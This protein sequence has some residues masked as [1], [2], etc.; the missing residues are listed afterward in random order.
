MRKKYRWVLRIILV[1]LLIGVKYFLFID[2]PVYINLKVEEKSDF[3]WTQEDKKRI[4]LQ[5]IK[6]IIGTPYIFCDFTHSESWSK[7]G[8]NDFSRTFFYRGFLIDSSRAVSVLSGEWTSKNDVESGYFIDDESTY[9]QL[10]FAINGEPVLKF[11]HHESHVPPYISFRIIPVKYRYHFQNRKSEYFYV[12]ISGNIDKRRDFPE[13]FILLAGENKFVTLSNDFN[14]SGFLFLREFELSEG[15]FNLLNEW[16]SNDHLSPLITLENGCYFSYNS[17]KREIFFFIPG[18]PQTFALSY[19]DFFDII[20]DIKKGYLKVDSCDTYYG[21]SPYFYFQEKKSDH[22]PIFKI[23]SDRIKDGQLKDIFQFCGSIPKEKDKW[24]SILAMN[25]DQ[26]IISFSSKKEEKNKGRKYPSFD[27]YKP[28]IIENGDKNRFC[29]KIKTVE[30][31]FKV[32]S[33]EI[34]ILEDQYILFYGEGA[35]WKMKWDGSEYA[36]IFPK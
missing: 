36:K 12:D 33:H 31:P 10:A 23:N 6:P 18:N 25:N 30:I 8:S 4:Y 7:P 20:P 29:E 27:I 19:D 1:A 34:A 3:G 32:E 35:L 16:K 17:F 28:S 2:K 22:C 9:N 21:R 14:N 11:S 5:K 13:D 24:T 26:V 15:K